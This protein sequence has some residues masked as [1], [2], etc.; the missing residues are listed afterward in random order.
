VSRRSFGLCL[1]AVAILVLLQSIAHLTATGPYG[2]L[3]SIVDLDR[4]N[5]I[6]DVVSTIVITIAAAGAVAVAWR[7]HGRERA[8][9]LLLAAS[10]CVIAV[11]DI[12]GVDRDATAAATL[13]VTGL[14][15]LAVAITAANA[16]EA[17]TRPAATIATGL[18]ALVATLVVGQL[19]ELAPWFERARG[20]MVI[21]LQII[22]KQGLELAGWSLVAIGLWDRAVGHGLE[23]AAAESHSI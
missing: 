18:V 10:L 6:P 17:G 2:E 4:S 7:A 14:A 5:A 15:V 21:E 23:T 20:D 3:D 9:A 13:T 22:V 16:G 11:D 19:P 8:S 1:A 12:V